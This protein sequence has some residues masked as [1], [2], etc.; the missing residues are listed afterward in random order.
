M[1]FNLFGVVYYVGKLLPQALVLELVVWG[2]S[3]SCYVDLP[4]MQRPKGSRGNIETKAVSNGTISKNCPNICFEFDSNPCSAV[5]NSLTALQPKNITYM[6]QSAPKERRRR[7]AEKWLSKRVFLESP[8]L[9]RPLKVCSA[10]NSPENLEGAEETDSPK[11]PFRT[12][13]SLHD[14]FAAPLARPQ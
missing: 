9:L 14:A 8:F 2:S 5:S 12:T 4:K 6:N 3:A 10:L 7:R 1:L 11:I 13:V